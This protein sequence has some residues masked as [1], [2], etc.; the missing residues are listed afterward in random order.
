[1]EVP[2][3]TFANSALPAYDA[4]SDVDQKHIGT[5]VQALRGSARP[6]RSILKDL[7]RGAGTPLYALRAGNDLRLLVERQQDGWLILDII[8][9]SAMAGMF[10]RV[11]R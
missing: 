1:M 5:A 11:A 7:S 9:H 4:L 2:Q 3:I 8:R 10:D 6:E